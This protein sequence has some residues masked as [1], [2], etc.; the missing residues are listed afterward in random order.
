MEKSIAYKLIGNFKLCLG[1]N[2]PIDVLL[3][4]MRKFMTSLA[5]Q[6]FFSFFWSSSMS[7]DFINFPLLIDDDLNKLLQ[8][9]KTSNY[10]EKTNTVLFILSDHGIRFGSFRQTTF[11]GMVEER[12]R[13]KHTKQLK[14]THI[15]YFLF[16]AFFFAVLPKSFKQTYPLAVRNLKRNARRLTTHYDVFETLKDL[17]NID[18]K[19]L[20]NER[21]L[22]R[23]DDINDRGKTSTL[24]RGIS[25]FLEIPEGRT[26]ESAGNKNLLFQKHFNH[27]C[28]SQF[29]FN[30]Q[31]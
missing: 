23:S 14:I 1:S 28:P 10:L 4:Y 3:K 7:H 21:L 26:C 27:F 8:E 13:K 18:S 25:L 17:S 24:P 6:P 22:L 11:Q 31:S 5:N 20:T 29:F 12:L 16:L 19:V 30:I 15:T 9:I 2:R